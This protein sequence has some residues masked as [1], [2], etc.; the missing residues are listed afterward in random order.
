[1]AWQDLSL[2][3]ELL[4]V[5]PL[6]FSPS[7]ID[8]LGGIRVLVLHTFGKTSNLS[9]CYHAGHVFLCGCHGP[10]VHFC[11]LGCGKFYGCGGLLALLAQT[12]RYL[13]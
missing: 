12:E 7:M 8:T 3:I 4:G 13:V 5:L 2:Y 10:C 1:M 11:A 6:I 9:T